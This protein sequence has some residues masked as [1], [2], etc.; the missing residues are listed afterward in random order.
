MLWQSSLLIAFVFALDFLLARKIRAS[1]RYALW[2][3]VLVKLLLPPT[4]A[5]PTGAA[6]WLFHAPPVAKAP[7]IKNYTVTYDTTPLADYVPPSIALPPPA[8]AEIGRRGLGLARDRHRQR[9]VAVVA[10]VALVAGR[11]HGS[12][13]N[14]FRRNWLA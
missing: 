10:G 6:W 8:A 13:R 9:G 3:A 14:R 11:P 7:A 1:V 12:G 2:L 4:L 5:L